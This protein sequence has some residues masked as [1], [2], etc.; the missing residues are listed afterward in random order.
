MDEVR[1]WVNDSGLGGKIRGQDG[2]KDLE[3]SFCPGK[4]YLAARYI[5]TDLNDMTARPS[6]GTRGT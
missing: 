2:V 6:P 5:F 4:G 1:A 3:L